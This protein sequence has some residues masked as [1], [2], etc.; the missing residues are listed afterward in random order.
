MVI[1]NPILLLIAYAI[2][3]NFSGFISGM[4]DVYY[5]LYV[6]F[7]S[8]GHAIWTLINNIIY[9]IE[10]PFNLLTLFTFQIPEVRLELT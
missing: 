9:S 8:T 1:L 6:L 4:T 3:G 7:S 2:G 10:A 5:L